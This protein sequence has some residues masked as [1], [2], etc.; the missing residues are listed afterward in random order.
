MWTD[1][2]DAII[3]MQHA[4]PVRR[5]LPALWWL[6]F[7]AL[8]IVLLIPLF[9]TEIP[10]LLDYPNHLA[11]MEI[12]SRLPGDADLA[13]I[14]ATS[15][16]I[17]PN[18][19]IDI[20]MPA[21]MHALPLMLA[22]KVFVGLALILPLV[23]VIVLHRS[24][25]GAVSFWPLA[26]GLVA[27]NRLFFS[28]FLNFL[29]GVGLALLGAALWRAL[30]DRSALLR[31]G[32]AIVAAVVIFF[33]HLIAVAFYGLILLSLE[34]AWLWKKRW[35]ERLGRLV[36]LAVPFV[37]PAIFYLRAP[38]S[39][40]TPTDG[41]GIADAI[42]HYYWALAASPPGLKLY[43]LMSP[44]LTYNRLLDTGALVLVIAVLALFA[45]ERRLRISPPLAAVFAFLLMAYPAVP[46]FLMQ[47]AWV[48]QRMPV[49]AGFLLFAGTLP[50][51][52]SGRT[53][54]LMVTAFAAAMLART[55]VIGLVWSGHDAQIADFR[56]VI[57]PVGP[58]DRV[59]VTQAERNADP[60][61]M[62]NRPDSVRAMRDNDSTMHLPALL[63][64][65]HK[66]FWPLLF[67]AATKQPVKVIAPYDA[68]SLPEGE[69]PWVG[70]LA[71]LDLATVKWAPYLPDWQ[72]KFDWVLVMHPGD[73]LGGY[74]LLPDRLEPARA[75]KIA[76]LYRIKK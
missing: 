70:S 53:A 46:F 49:L 36:L 37:I 8:I 1:E 76:T 9:L 58:G 24:L 16:G 21:L 7:V 33:C 11:R 18:I 61:A 71:E 5:A 3:D 57:S 68:I 27:Y 50:R 52:G 4:P 12:L 40:D 60:Q 54:R 47:T 15:W 32:T 38:I 25:F 2:R 20:A 17:V 39:G 75:G 66:A 51:V 73:A 45:S 29:I 62:V 30:Q 10:P 72:Q 28:G 34:L 67:T 63:V 48:D 65:E 14:Y 26:A 6:A 22:G 13:R 44:F 55:V 35:R 69:L 56:Q 43:G 41:N 31:V 64:I 23:G 74:D 42:R 19:G 59:L